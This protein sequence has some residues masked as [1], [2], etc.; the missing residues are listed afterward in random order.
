MKHQADKRGSKRSFNIGDYVYLRLQ[1]YVLAS[2]VPRLHHKLCFK[3]FSPFY[4][5]D[6]I[7]ER[8]SFSRQ[9]PSTYPCSSRRPLPRQ[10]SPLSFPSL[11]TPIKYQNECCSG[12][13]I[14]AAL[15]PCL[16]S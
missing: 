8:T 16:S 14:L 1:P 13:F 10:R 4:I 12:A 6:K 5:V 11:T 7:N 3:Y 2:L 9:Q 15:D